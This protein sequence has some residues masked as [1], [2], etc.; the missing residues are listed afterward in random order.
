MTH[1]HKLP[2]EITDAAQDVAQAVSS[3]ASG[4][5]A[6]NF[7]VESVAA[8]RSGFTLVIFIRRTCFAQA[9]LPFSLVG[10]MQALIALV[11]LPRGVKLL[12]GA[13]GTK[14][15]EN[16]DQNDFEI[17]VHRN[18]LRDE[19]LADSGDWETI[20]VGHDTEMRVPTSKLPALRAF[21]VEACSGAH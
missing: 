3:F 19:N 16:K 2:F 9:S 13:P 5:K 15:K 12:R 7:L 10:Q 8:I 4:A 14:P 21:G 18:G 1:I 11:G 20:T 17:S 6:F